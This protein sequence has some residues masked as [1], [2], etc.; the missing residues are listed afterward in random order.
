MRC[1]KMKNKSYYIGG[2]Y[3]DQKY[4]LKG[5]SIVMALM[6][7]VSLYGCSKKTNA[8]DTKNAPAASTAQVSEDNSNALSGK[9][10]PSADVDVVSKIPGRVASVNV[11]EGQQVK[12]GDALFTLE[13]KDIKL[14][15]NQAEAAVKIAE[16]A[17]EKAKGGAAEQ[18]ISQ[19]KA[20]VA[21]AESNYNLKLENRQRA[22]QTSDKNMVQ[23]I[24]TNISLETAKTNLDNAIANRERVRQIDDTA[25]ANA[26][27][28]LKDVKENLEDLK[29]LKEA[30]AISQQA[31]D[32]VQ[33]KYDT[34]MNTLEAAKIAKDRDM[35][36]QDGSVKSAEDQYNAAQIQIKKDYDS[37]DNDLKA[38]QIQLNA[39]REALQI[40]Q[41]KTI[42][43]SIETAQSQLQQAQAALATAQSQLDNT[44]I[45]AAIDGIVASKNIEVGEMVGATTVMAKVVDIASVTVEVNVQDNLVN[46]LK[47]GDKVKV[48]VKSA[49]SKPF[50]GEIISISPVAD[51]KA[52]SY[53]VKIKVNNENGLL[54]GDMFAEV[55]FNQ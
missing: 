20:D 2:I 41:S 30:G 52:Q 45:K 37:A 33:L 53:P 15:V 21:Q 55:L 54:K 51:T 10:K 1:V 42:P 49:D 36:I 39:K 38:A 27:A 18:Q 3:M 14:Q 25:I 4:Y 50:E 17:L 22:Q 5:I 19:L 40:A 48:L 47:V 23:L 24:T 32:T 9:V 12:A 6:M 8:A 31:L 28:S 43:E 29:K 13:D 11:K 35:A 46:K 7:S 26:E 34:A 44:V 16:V